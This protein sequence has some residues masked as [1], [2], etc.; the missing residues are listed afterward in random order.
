MRAFEDKKN[1]VSAEHSA[2]R[3]AAPGHS[4][5]DVEFNNLFDLLGVEEATK[6]RDPAEEELTATAVSESSDDEG[7]QDQPSSSAKKPRKT[8]KSGKK[9]GKGR[10]KK[11]KTQKAVKT[12]ASVDVKE[13]DDMEWT[14]TSGSI[15]WDSEDEEDELY[16]MIVS[17]SRCLIPSSGLS[18]E[19]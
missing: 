10:A 13:W 11:P 14:A 19:L 18:R 8:A 4:K 5:S 1:K 2:I 15:E 16:F 9:K 17:I 12:S 7:S 3:E 6:S